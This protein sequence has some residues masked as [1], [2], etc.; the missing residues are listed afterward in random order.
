MAGRLT[1]VT[2]DGALVADYSYDANG[3]RTAVPTPSGTVTA[4]YDAQDR[5]TRYG[6]TTYGYTQAGD[7]ESKTGPAGTSTYDY[8]AL[9][10]LRRVE[11]APGKTIDYVIDGKNRRIGKKVDG[12]LVQGFLY[13]DPLNPIA[14]LDGSGNV[15]ARFVYGAKPN[16]PAYMIKG[17][18]R[19][20][21]ISDHLGS[22]RLV[23]NTATGAIAQRLDYGPFGQVTTD[24]NPGFQPFGFAGGLY[25]RDTGLVRFG[26]RDYVPEV[27]RWTAKDPIL[28]RGGSPNLYGYVVN[29]P[30]N[31]VDPNGK[32]GLAGAAIGGAIGAVSAAVGTAVT[33]GSWSAIATSAVTG[34]VTGAM[35]GSGAGLLATVSRGAL[36]GGAENLGG[37]LGGIYFNRNKSLCDFNT[38]AFIGS[39]IGGGLGAG[40][41][42]VLRD[43]GE[44]FSP[45][46]SRAVLSGSPALVAGGIGGHIG[47]G[48]DR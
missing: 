15:E 24:T 34:G 10:N 28:F 36:V 46:F 1:R 41:A 7:L 37:Q 27:G 44:S 8:D 30:V 3:N 21:I 11:L 43:A 14:E 5:L 23:I 29:D 38:G 18:T 33:G 20:R 25:D 31:F 45:Q 48:S 47:S 6:D 13:K 19:Y 9:G 22:V 4:A 17:G 42:S 35:V 39:V 16:V 26:A 12:T 40:R 32:F 2:R